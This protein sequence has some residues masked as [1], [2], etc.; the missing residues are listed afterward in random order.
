MSTLMFSYSV[1]AAETV[2][3]PI[4][5]Y[6][7][8]S[9]N[10]TY[11]GD[12]VV[13]AEMFEEDMKYLYDLSYETVT[14]AELIAYHE[15]NFTLPEK[16]IMIT[17]DDGQRSFETYALPILEKYGMTAVLSIVGNYTDIYTENGDRNVA[18]SYF[19]WSDIEK[20]A[21]NPSVDIAAHSYDMHENVYRQGVK[22]ISGETYADY[23]QVLRADCEKLETKLGF[24]PLAYTFPFG[25]YSAESID[26]LRDHGYEVIF[27]CNEYVNILDGS[28]DELLELGRYNRPYSADR[29]SFFGK[30]LK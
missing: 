26:I 20:L 3:L 24:M 19:S 21:E 10:E 8:I 14:L 27:T 18:Y 2:D 25:F 22:I 29:E 23:S 30:I 17:F 5:M 15:G 28:E 7:H 12:Y 13:T 4:I 9:E 11:C 16:P 6:H 1:A